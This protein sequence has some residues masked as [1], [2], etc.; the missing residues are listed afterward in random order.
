MN[1]SFTWRIFISF[2]LFISFCMLLVSG[3]ILYIGPSGRAPSTLV[4]HMLGLTKP[5]WQNQHVIFGFAL[6][7]LV[8]FHLFLINWQAFLSY[9]KK[10]TKESLASPVELLVIVMIS[11]LFGIGTYYKIQPFSSIL[12]FGKSISKSWDRGNTHVIPAT[13]K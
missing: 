3:V 11:L 4:W 9:L 6:S 10:R 5:E 2:G 8:L 12:E 1:R 7:L 13:H